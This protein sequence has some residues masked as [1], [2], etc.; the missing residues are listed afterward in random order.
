MSERREAVADL[1]YEV[2]DL[3]RKAHDAAMRAADLLHGI[4]DVEGLRM[5][6]PRSISDAICDVNV[7]IDELHESDDV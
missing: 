4:E 5:V 3:L 2:R 7:G 1:T 6:V